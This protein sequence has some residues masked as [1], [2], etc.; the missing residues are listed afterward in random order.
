MEVLLE[1]YIFFL[2]SVDS[3][4]DVMAESRG[5]KEDMILK[6]VF[7]RLYCKGNKYLLPKRLQERLTSCKLKVK[8]KSTAI[9]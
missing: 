8:N 2:D 5:G 6:K 7:S 4:G 3:V 1:R 9:P